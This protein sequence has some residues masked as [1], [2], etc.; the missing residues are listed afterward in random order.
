MDLLVHVK[1]VLL[2]S[3][4]VLGDASF[5]L[6]AGFG[7]AGLLHVL[8]PDEKVMKYLGRSAGRLRSVINA[9]VLGVPLPL[10]SCGVIPA[11]ISLKKRGATRGATLSFLI[12]TP[13]TGVDSIAITYAL[14]DPIMTV[15]R[16]V[17]T[18][19]TAITA[20]L[21]ENV[22]EPVTSFVG[23]K[24]LDGEDECS[25]ADHSGCDP[26]LAS[27][28]LP[29]V[30]STSDGS[31]PCCESSCCESS[32]C[33]P[34]RGGSSL[35]NGLKYAYIDLMGDIA[36]WLVVGILLAGLISYA[37][38]AEL[39]STYL[40]GGILS[41]FLALV[42]GIP[43]YICATASTPLAAVLIAKGMSPGAAFVFLLAGPATNV[44]TITMV[45]KFLG[46]RSALVYLSSIAVCALLFGL[47]L[48]LIYGMLGVDASSIAGSAGALM[49]GHARDIF[50]LILLPLML[51]GFVRKRYLKRH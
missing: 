38:P 17:A 39:I 40:G 26:I 5:Y 34:S 24:T 20:G 10:C 9:S 46:K 4:N 47:L 51:Y 36:L 49:P 43:L 41:M 2:E 48:D 6:L 23:K 16:P 30:S 50:A 37:M 35:L 14:L 28:V 25:C 18:T 8:L 21:M 13:Q 29:M 15:F 44:A 42:V 11:A 27:T 19:V 1:G 7:I 3:W 22:V 45:L 33:A 32:C 31:D 12:S